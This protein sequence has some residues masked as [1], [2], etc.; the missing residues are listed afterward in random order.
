MGPLMVPFLNQDR[1]CELHAV[2][3][4][5]SSMWR[6]KSSTA[7]LLATTDLTPSVWHLCSICMM[8]FV[9]CSRIGSTEPWPIGALGPRN[10]AKGWAKG[11]PRIQ[12]DLLKW[13]G[14]LSTARDIY[15]FGLSFHWSPSWTPLVPLMGYRGQN[16]MSKPV[17]QTNMST[18]M[19]SPVVS[20]MPLGTIS[21][22]ASVT[23]G[24]FSLVKAS[25]YPLPG[26]VFDT[27]R[28]M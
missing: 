26:W 18:W 4:I 5:N 24:T 28:R 20:L 11:Y 6:V 7:T 16:E 13:L 10:T 9:A 22:M 14:K 27:P 1:Q 17:A 12:R 3:F 19:T 2:R 23:T 8:Y 15:P 21:E 25:R